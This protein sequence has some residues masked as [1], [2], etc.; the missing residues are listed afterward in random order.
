METTSYQD[1][2]RLDSEDSFGY[3]WQEVTPIGSG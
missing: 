1:N 2:D 3:K